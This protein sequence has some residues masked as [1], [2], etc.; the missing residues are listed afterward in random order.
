[1]DG[2]SVWGKVGTGQCREYLTFCWVWCILRVE[3]KMVLNL[4]DAQRIADAMTKG[5]FRCL[6]ENNNLV[7]EIL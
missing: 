2:V 5:L 3:V 4:E 1:M 6:A 7:P